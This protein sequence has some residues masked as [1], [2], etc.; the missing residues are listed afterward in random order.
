MKTSV[1]SAFLLCLALGCGKSSSEGAAVAQPAN[2]T[3][4]APAETAQA[5]KPA[6]QLTADKAKAYVTFEDEYWTLLMDAKKTLG[7]MGDKAKAGKY[8]GALGSYQA[9]DELAQKNQDFSQKTAALQKKHGL[10]PAEID[11][12]DK[13]AGGVH[14]RANPMLQQSFAHIAEMEKMRDKVPAAAQSD[15][16]KSIAEMKKSQADIE[17]LREQRDEYGDAIVDAMIAQQPALERQLKARGLG[18]P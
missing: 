15:L 9:I 1:C 6:L 4:P 5:S 8:E 18:G 14:A 17:S 16:D 7:E 2:A 10:T 13:I 11:A 3:A 12:L